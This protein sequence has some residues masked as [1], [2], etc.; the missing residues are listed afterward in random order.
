MG[1]GQGEHRCIVTISQEDRAGVCAQSIHKVRAVVFLDL[2]GLLVLADDVV[3]VVFNMADSDK[4][5]LRVFT[6]DLAVKIHGRFWL[7]DKNAIGLKL[8][9]V[10]GCLGIDLRVISAHAIGKINLRAVHVK[11]AVGIPCG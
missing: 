9:E 6:H 7:T 3:F 5:R 11:K 2:A 4:P 10:L 8:R 1:L